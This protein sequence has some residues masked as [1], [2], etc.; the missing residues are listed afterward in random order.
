VKTTSASSEASARALDVGPVAGVVE[1]RGVEPLEQAVLDHDLLAAAALLGRRA[2][3]DDLAGQV[4]G[5]R[6]QRDRAPT[7]DAAIV[8]WPHP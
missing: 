8:L 6:R 5:D 3:E 2:E 4:V 1:Q 7:P